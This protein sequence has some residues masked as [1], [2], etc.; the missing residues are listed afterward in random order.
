MG[1]WPKSSSR[2]GPWAMGA[3][4]RPAGIACLGV[5]RGWKGVVLGM[6]S[7]GVSGFCLRA[8]VVGLAGGDS[9]IAPQRPAQQGGKSKPISHPGRA[10]SKPKGCRG[11]TPT[12]APFH[13]PVW[14][15]TQRGLAGTLGCGRPS[16]GNPSAAAVPD[17]RQRGPGLGVRRVIW[18]R[19]PFLSC[20]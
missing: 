17:V 13:S 4:P 6:S 10:T 9:G 20:V 1:A 15:Q 12:K 2:W 18:G 7:H 3:R 16:R 5:E 8:T 11:A 19:R 14:P